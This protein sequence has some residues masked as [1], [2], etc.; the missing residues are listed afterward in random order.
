L[1]SAKIQPALTA[2][3]KS[4]PLKPNKFPFAR[5]VVS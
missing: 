1:V 4:L 2:R 5:R 3:P